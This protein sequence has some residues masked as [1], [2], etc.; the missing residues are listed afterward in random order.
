M[1][2]NEKSIHNDS[3]ERRQEISVFVELKDGKIE[4][5]HN[6]FIYQPAIN[7]KGGSIKWHEDLTRK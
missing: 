1:T 4:K 2:G 6:T 3:V 5:I 7:F